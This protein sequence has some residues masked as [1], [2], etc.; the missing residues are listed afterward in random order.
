MLKYRGEVSVGVGK[1]GGGANGGDR[2][3]GGEE[4]GKDRGGWEG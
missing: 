2:L 1:K 4:G 3:V